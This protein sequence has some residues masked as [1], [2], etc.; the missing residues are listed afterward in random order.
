MPDRGKIRLAS[1][2]F[3]SGRME[4]AILSAGNL[5]TTQGNHISTSKETPFLQIGETKY[6]KPIMDRIITPQT[7]L[8]TAALCSLVSMDSTIR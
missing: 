1:G 3:A 2:S 7:P 8:N 5:A 4:I 6:G